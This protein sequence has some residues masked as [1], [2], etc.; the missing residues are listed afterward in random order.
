MFDINGNCLSCLARVNTVRDYVSLDL[1][2]ENRSAK[3]TLCIGEIHEFT[4]SSPNYY[5][6][7]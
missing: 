6:T 4:D 7:R 5:R 2:P 3:V 1:P